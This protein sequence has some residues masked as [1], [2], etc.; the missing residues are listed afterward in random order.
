MDAD[1]DEY[2]PMIGSEL[3]EGPAHLGTGVTQ[4]ASPAGRGE[5]PRAIA[6]DRRRDAVV[7]AHPGQD[8][9]VRAAVLGLGEGRRHDAAIPGDAGR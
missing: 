3:G 1:E 6:I 5:D 7:A 2:G 4:R 8:G 9:Q